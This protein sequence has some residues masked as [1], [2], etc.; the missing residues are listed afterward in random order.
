MTLPEFKHTL[1][2]V[3][4]CELLELNAE[5]VRARLAVLSE[6]PEEFQ[7]ALLRCDYLILTGRA[8]FSLSTGAGLDPV[9][10]A[11]RFQIYRVTH[12]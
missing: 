1:D 4:G 5:R 11:P 9:F 6:I 7:A 10:V 3:I 12:S 2:G 8:D